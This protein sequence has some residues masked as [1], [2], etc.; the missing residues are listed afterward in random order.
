MIWEDFWSLLLGILNVSYSWMFL[1]LSTL[2]VFCYNFSSLPFL[3]LGIKSSYV[4]Q[5]G[6]ELTVVILVPQ[7]PKCWE[8]RHVPSPQLYSFPLY[9]RLIFLIYS[10]ILEILEVVVMIHSLPVA[11]WMYSQCISLSMLFDLLSFSLRGAPTPQLHMSLL[12]Y[13]GCWISCPSPKLT[14]LYYLFIWIMLRS[15]I[16]L[17]IRFL[18]IRF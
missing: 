13:S 18:K 7:T 14:F 15:L 10:K 11:V 5:A 8:C 12:N 1:F 9:Q 2:R 16:I 3:S 17:K 4:A 6:V